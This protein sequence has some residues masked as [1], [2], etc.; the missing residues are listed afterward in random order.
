MRHAAGPLALVAMI[1]S[2][3]EGI[4]SSVCLEEDSTAAAHAMHDAGA[5]ANHGEHAPGAPADDADRPGDAN[6]PM[7][8][9]APSQCAPFAIAAVV[10]LSG[11][12]PTI[13]GAPVP[14]SSFR[15]PTSRQGVDL[16]HPP[17]A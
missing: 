7:S 2:M 1:F 14:A 4:A 6:C 3:F 5:M 12:V 17:R 13:A 16:F 15:I 11:P 9:A 10:R 8:G